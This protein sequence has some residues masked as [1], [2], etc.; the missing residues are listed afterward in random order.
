MKK[1]DPRPMP[2]LHQAPNAALNSIK[3][4]NNDAAMKAET[5]VY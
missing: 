5:W 3:R 1:V 4:L 2:T